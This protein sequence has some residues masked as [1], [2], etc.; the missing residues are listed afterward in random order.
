MRIAFIGTGRMGFPMARN[1]AAAGH[2]LRVYDA[3]PAAAARLASFDRV[4]VAVTL[5]AVVEDAEAVITSLPGPVDVED[6]ILG[7]DGIAAQMAP[8]TLYLDLS[9]NAPSVVRRIAA[10]L[11][12]RGVDMLDCPVSGGVE[13]AEAATL[14][15]MA[16]GSETAFARARPLL[17]AIGRK[18]FYCGAA[19]SGSVVK[20]CN[21]L[22]GIG[23]TMI[24]AEAL[25]LGVK[26][27]VDLGTLASVI[28]QST[29]GS[30]RL[31][32]RFPRYL[33]RGNFTPGFSSALSFKD[34]SLALAL[35]DELG[36]PL[37]LGEQ[38]RAEL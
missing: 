2:T 27:G 30:T 29:G 26:A 35:G 32:D 38:V 28:G 15:V 16:G 13:G 24:L 11:A 31:N 1:L 14:S 22:C 21:N 33:F 36:V 10:A 19:G 37:N 9:T 6:V 20:L 25:T 12:V 5:A 23:N 7:P 34:T 8:G 3:N 18:V 4:E 17:E